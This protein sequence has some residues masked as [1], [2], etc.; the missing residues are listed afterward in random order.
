MQPAKPSLRVVT[1][2]HIA[3]STPAMGSNTRWDVQLLATRPIS[4]R[5]KALPSHGLRITHW[6][7][8]IKGRCRPAGG[9]HGWRGAQG[10]RLRDPEA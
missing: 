2:G 6:V 10:A 1:R 4:R 7:G 8:R 9:G 5:S 3:C